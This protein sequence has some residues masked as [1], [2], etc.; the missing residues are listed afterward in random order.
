MNWEHLVQEL[1][2]LLED[3][4]EDLEKY[5][6]KGNKAAGQRVRV[7]SVIFE[8]RAKEFRKLSVSRQ[9]NQHAKA[10]R[11]TVKSSATAKKKS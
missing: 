10:K 2:Q 11:K 8:K 5:A 6:E 7:K 1:K 3:I 4:Y 9:K